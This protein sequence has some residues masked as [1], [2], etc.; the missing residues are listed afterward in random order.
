MY[1]SQELSVLGHFCFIHIF[2]YSV[3][4]SPLDYCEGNIDIMIF[5]HP[6][7]VCIYKMQGLFL[8]R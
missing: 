1:I 6:I 3:F 5:Y 8:K 7:L 2:T 4:Y